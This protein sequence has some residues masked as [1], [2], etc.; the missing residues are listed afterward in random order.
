MAASVPRDLNIVCAFI[1]KSSVVELTLNR[2]TPL[3]EKGFPKY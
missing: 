1:N 2:Q 3:V